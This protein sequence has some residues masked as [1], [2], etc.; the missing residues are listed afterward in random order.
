[1]IIFVLSL[2]F[3]AKI[4]FCGQSEERIRLKELNEYLEILKHL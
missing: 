3:G 2:K 1:M 4:Q